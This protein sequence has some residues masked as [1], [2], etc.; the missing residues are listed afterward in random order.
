MVAKAAAVVVIVVVITVAAVVV[1]AMAEYYYFN[2]VSLRKQ[3]NIKAMY[4][5]NHVWYTMI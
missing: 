1:A 5:P 2:F 4:T 3:Y